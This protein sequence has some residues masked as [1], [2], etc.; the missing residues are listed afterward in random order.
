MST[1]LRRLKPIPEHESLCG[2]ND[3]FLMLMWITDAQLN[4][5]RGDFDLSAVELDITL[6]P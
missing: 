5:P 6:Q 4:T 3:L 2:G 1:R